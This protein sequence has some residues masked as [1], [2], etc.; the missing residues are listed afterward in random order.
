MASKAPPLEEIDVILPR[1]DPDAWRFRINGIALPGRVEVTGAV[2]A[3]KW[4]VKETQS[5]ARV[6]TIT[7]KGESPPKF[8]VKCTV[9]VQDD[10]DALAEVLGYLQTSG[11][12]P[13]DPN[14]PKGKQIPFHSKP[15]RVSHASLA[16]L[17]IKHAVV[18]DIGALVDEGKGCVSV[19]ISWLEWWPPEP[20]PPKPATQTSLGGGAFETSQAKA[21][22]AGAPPGD[23][24]PGAAPNLGPV[25]VSKLWPAAPTPPS[26]NGPPKPK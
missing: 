9:A 26:A 6:A 12:V 14:N 24:P 1:T 25:D 7:L 15:Q 4:D 8:K 21:A 11:K 20:D 3:K 5:S 22:Y 16:S 2:R 13:Q 17:G 10:A 23:Y 19:T 18:D